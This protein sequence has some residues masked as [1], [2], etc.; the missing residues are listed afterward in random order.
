MSRRSTVWDC[1]TGNGQAATGLARHFDRVIATDA[2]AEQ[3]AHAVPASGVEY[4]VAAAEQSGLPDKSVQLVT[5]AQALHWLSFDAFYAEVRRVTAPGGFLAVWSYGFC[6]AGDDIEEWFRE[7]EEGQLGPWWNP[8]RRWVAERYRSIP[9]PFREVEAP[10]FELH[11]E[12]TLT[13]L[14]GYLRSWSAVGKYVRM[15]GNDPVAPFL[16]LLASRWKPA[17][18]RRDVRWPLALRVGRVE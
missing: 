1:C 16:E 17:G 18:A 12:W 2:S 6:H 10:T 14:G 13:Q 15:H 7:F 9:F 3:I 11:K 4:R 5:V 8:E